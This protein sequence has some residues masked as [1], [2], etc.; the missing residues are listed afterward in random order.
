MI[1]CYPT[2]RL[3]LATP[4]SITRSKAAWEYRAHSGELISVLP[5]KGEATAPVQRRLKSREW[6]ILGGTELGS[7]CA[8]WLRLSRVC[9][10]GKQQF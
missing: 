8:G 3:L 4:W 2:S 1:G 7:P 10:N 9:T 6:H 5:V